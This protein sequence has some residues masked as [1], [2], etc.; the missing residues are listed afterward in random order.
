MTIDNKSTA[1]QIWD[2]LLRE[3]LK[4]QLTPLNRAKH[5]NVEDVRKAVELTL[6]AGHRFHIT[7]IRV[8]IDETMVLAEATTQRMKELKEEH[9]ATWPIRWAK[10]RALLR[11]ANDQLMM[12]RAY[13]RAILVI[14]NTLPEKPA[15]AEEPEEKQE[16]PSPLTVSGRAIPHLNGVNRNEEPPPC[17]DCRGTG[18]ASA[19]EPH[20]GQLC[21]ACKGTGI[22]TRS[23]HE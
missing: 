7:R 22:H 11:Q 6:L 10:R 1:L 4:L 21:A 23:D 13:A 14:A 5:M 9:A 8:L 20:D 2:T 17:P 15:A 16:A 19:L 12:Q 18:Y 3:E